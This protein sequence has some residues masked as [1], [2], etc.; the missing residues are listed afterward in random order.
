MKLTSIEKKIVKMS[1]LLADL[2][3]SVSPEFKLDK[4]R[5]TTKEIIQMNLEISNSSLVNIINNSFYDFKIEEF[6]INSFKINVTDNLAIQTKPEL[7]IILD[8]KNNFN[9]IFRIK[10]QFL[11]E[12]CSIGPIKIECRINGK[13]SFFI[14]NRGE[15]LIN[16][17]A[18]PTS[19]EVSLTNLKPPLIDK[20]FPI[21]I[22]IENNSQG[23]ASD[24][25]IEIK[26]PEGIKV[27]RGTIE[28]QIYSLRSKE[29]IKWEINARPL[30]AGDY[31]IEIYLKFKDP[32]DNSMEEKKLFPIAIKL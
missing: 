7:P 17:F 25:N 16:L 10:P 23:E 24:L 21:E 15:M 9:N 13:Y 4:E 12:K 8:L 3:V 14:E 29:K 22:L 6:Q 27:I 5:Y 1:I 18:P 20:S 31:E 28:K 32:D 26:F 30:E 19:L 11:I 2:H